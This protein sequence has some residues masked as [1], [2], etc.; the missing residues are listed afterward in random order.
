MCRYKRKQG[1]DRTAST[2]Q[3]KDDKEIIDLVS[4]MLGNQASLTVRRNSS[5]NVPSPGPT[6]TAA[7]ADIAR[8]LQ[9]MALLR[10]VAEPSAHLPL[11][12]PGVAA[13]PGMAAAV[14]GVQSLQ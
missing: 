14:P 6:P 8:L 9:K 2:E 12:Q 1:D 4:K 7:G 3:T 5:S 10:E 13:E 11:Q